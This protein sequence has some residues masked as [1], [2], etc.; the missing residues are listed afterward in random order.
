MIAPDE[1][2]APASPPVVGDDKDQYTVKSLSRGL[3][4]LRLFDLE[5]P[6]WTLSDLVRATRLHK[7]TCY[8]LVRTLEQEGFLVS[9]TLSGQ[10]SL[11]PALKRAAVLAM[12][13]DEIVRSARPHLER[14]VGITGETVDLT[15]WSDEGPLLAAQVLSRSRMFQPMNSLGTVFTEGPACHVKLWLGFGSQA[16]RERLWS[17]LTP[18]HQGE[19]PDVTGLRAQLETIRADGVAY[20]VEE[21]RGVFA[22]GAPV[23]DAAQRMVAA[24][25]VVASYDRT[26]DAQRDLCAAAV[27]QVALALSV[28]LGA[29]AEGPQAPPRL[30]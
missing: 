3:G 18:D 1:T 13:G 26:G 28:E 11:G 5:H 21:R 19:P 30:G 12:A 9:D 20:D 2:P 17:L 22:V 10:Y 25:A 16:Q 7:A 27:R 4:L 23:F 24:M 15:V 14:L 29:P 6:R 8:R